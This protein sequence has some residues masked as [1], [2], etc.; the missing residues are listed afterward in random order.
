MNDKQV[1]VCIVQIWNQVH[2]K[3]LSDKMKVISIK[4]MQCIRREIYK[5]KIIKRQVMTVRVTQ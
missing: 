2:R 5:P 4:C 3:E 1:L